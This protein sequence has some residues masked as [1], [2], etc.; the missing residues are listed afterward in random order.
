[1][2]GKIFLIGDSHI[3]LGFP[4]KT[5]RW[6]NV[7]KEY[8]SEFLIPLLKR[9]VTE[10]DIIVMNNLEIDIINPEDNDEV[11]GIIKLFEN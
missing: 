8:F 3:G 11:F 10:G 1:M 2:I 7:H 6:F 4:N 5:D 9:E